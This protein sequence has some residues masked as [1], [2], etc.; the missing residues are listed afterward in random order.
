MAETV[1]GLLKRGAADL[2]WFN[3][4]TASLRKQYNN[5]F[6]A[7]KDAQVL[8]AGDDVDQVLKTLTAEGVDAKGTLIRFVSRVKAIL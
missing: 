3:T 1:V 4:H 2:D 5:K 8:C 6:V 7:I